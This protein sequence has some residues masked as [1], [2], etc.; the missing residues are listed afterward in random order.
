MKAEQRVEILWE[1]VGIVGEPIPELVPLLEPPLAAAHLLSEIRA[2]RGEVPL[3]PA[4][5]VQHGAALAAEDAPAE[6]RV[7]ALVARQLLADEQVPFRR[8]LGECPPQ[9]GRRGAAVRGRAHRAELVGRA[10]P[11][12]AHDAKRPR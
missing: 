7:P 11:D 5:G 10:V 12:E 4:G 8:E 2:A 1:T 3:P 9:S 6:L